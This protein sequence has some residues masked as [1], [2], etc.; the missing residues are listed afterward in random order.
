MSNKQ[1][2]RKRWG[3][4]ILLVA[5]ALLLLSAIGTKLLSKPEICAKR[6]Q[7]AVWETD[8]ELQKLINNEADFTQYDKKSVGLYIFHNDSLTYWNNNAVGPKLIRRKITI[9]QDTICNLL[10]G[11][12][13]VKSYEKGS[14]TFYVI[15]LL[16]TTYKLENPYFENRFV[17]FK[18]R[19]NDKIS[20]HENEG[21]EIRSTD[22]K[23]LT[24]C[25]IK[26]IQG[27]T[28][29]AWK[30]LFII[31]LLLLVIA[32]VLFFTKTKKVQDKTPKFKLEYGIMV[33]IAL[34]IL[35]T[36]LYYRWDQKRE[37]EKMKE[38]A[39]ILL[40]KRDTDFEQSFSAF[41]EQLKSDT[42]LRDMVFAESNVLGEVILGYSKE[43]LFDET[44]KAYNASLTVCHPEEEITVQPEGYIVDCD[45]YFL[46]KLANNEKER[47]GEYLYFINY[48]T[49]DPNYLAKIKVYSKDTLQQ[50]TLYFEFY[51]PIAPEGFGFPQ[52]LQDK[53][54]QKPNDYSVANYKNEILVYKY[55]RYIYPNF[56]NNLNAK[57][58]EFTIDEKSKHFTFGDTHENALVISTPRKGWSEITAPF[59]VFFLGMLIPFLVIYWLLKP[60][61]TRRWKDRSFRRR[62]QTM[63]L[64]TMALAVVAV[65]PVSV[66]YM[67]SLYN[68]KTTETQFETTRTLTTELSKDIDFNTLLETASRDTWTEILQQYAA[69]FF[70]DLNLYSLDGRLLATTRQEIYELT[71]QAPIMNAEAFQNMHRNK[72]L[73]YT[74]EE[75]LGKGAYASAY[76]PMNDENG[77]TLAYLNTPYFSSLTDLH[78]E[79]LNFVLT[80]IN[81]VLILLGL[82]LILVLRI[83]NRLTQPLSLIQNKLGDLKIDQKNEPIEWK[84]N[85][86][87][88]A[89]VKQYNQLIVELE[90]ST[91][92][93]KRTT[94]ESAW[95]GVA[96][97]VAHEIKNSLTPMRLSVQMLQRN[98]EN[99]KATP[100][101]T[102]R[103]TNTLIEQIDALSD[104]ASSFSRYAKLPENHPEPLD[105][106]ELV[107][108]I[109]NLYD[110]TDNITFKYDYEAEKDH[111][112]VGDKTNL[113]SAIG[114]IVKNAT[115]AIGSK[116]NG[117]IEV[118]LKAT[119]TQ[120]LIAVKDNGK[121]IKEEDKKMI[122]VPNFTTKS[123]GSG[124]GLSLA[125]NI[126]KSAGGTISFESQE[127][128]GTTF[129]IELPR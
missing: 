127:G 48:N 51:K 18:I 103:T 82:A 75:H 17:P 63:V 60:K 115:Q 36:Y 6:I 54:S 33:I 46:E 102:Q 125:Y 44:M 11:D 79:I 86:E 59:A 120:Y 2:H 32:L 37:N 28:I 31:G 9:G 30:T 74:H 89:L 108:N 16:N 78:K 83:T 123:G 109:I 52:L 29:T 10:T 38:L 1:K 113:N 72:A 124:V 100:E 41:A 93:L 57:E 26:P 112:F 4:V 107:G 101:Q 105:L 27:T 121:G 5:I 24:Y 7:R 96:R 122:F 129:T 8:K 92:E 23:L 73:Y 64:T 76:I 61:E 98:I 70:T 42:A 67:R 71:L 69:T 65:A 128:V 104:I 88:G 118:S 20:L 13:Y 81:I 94:A 34:S 40:E 68:K 85:D 39:E 97:Q 99:G 95:R 22:N 55:G 19:P 58:N 50:Q 87:I 49:L 21:F 53:H 43:L 3:W 62:M 84:G 117:Q 111:T 114:N 12:Y 119:Q 56:I 15:K 126:I 110:N 80:Y 25:R 47:I 77:Y 116:A 91:K 45:D 66:I 90:K 106:A 14:Q 35:G